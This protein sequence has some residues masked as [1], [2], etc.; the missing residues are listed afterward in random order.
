M[1]DPVTDYAL[2]VLDGKLPAGPYVIWACERHLRDLEREDIF[3]DLEEV[4]RRVGFFKLLKHYKDPF[5]GAPFELSPWQV[6]RVGS[7][8]GWKRRSDGLRRFRTA[9]TEIPRKNGKTTE[10]AGVGLSGMV[11]DGERGA[12]VY[13]VATK[14]DQAKIVWQDATKMAQAT[15]ELNKRLRFF[16]SAIVF[17]KMSARFMPLGRDSK[18]LDGLN[19]YLGLYDEF[20]AW[21]DRELRGK[22]RQGMGSRQQPLEWIVTT[23]GVD[24]ETLAFE[25]RGHAL[26]VLNP[27]LEDFDDDTLFAYIACP[28]PDDDP[29]DPATWWRANPNLEVSKSLKYLEGLW[30]TARMIPSEMAD[31]LTYQLNIW[32]QS[33]ERWLDLKRVKDAEV[34]MELSELAA[35]PC[36]AG[37]DLAE[38]GDLSAKCD[39]FIA[40]DGVWY[41]L[42]KFWCPEDDILKRSQLDKVPYSQWVRQGYLTSTPGN[43]TDFD[44][45]EAEVRASA[46]ALEVKELLYDRWKS[47]TIV[48]NLERDAVVTTVPYG[49]GYKDQSPALKEIERRFLNGTLKFIK[50]P[51]FSWCC[52]NAEVMRDPAGNIKLTKKD[53]RKRID[54]LA[55]LAN[56]VGGALLNKEEAGPSV[57]EDRGIIEL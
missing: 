6:F 10:M 14:R 23:A 54:G 39:L 49:Q 19:P 17:E 35:W 4:Q 27:E 16:V 8:Y 13:S 22:I 15:P 5:Y 9:Y 33:S 52:S 50:N 47:Q 51:V 43:A 46:E 29:G 3:L 20:H 34:E 41:A 12:E 25:L 31:F 18:S 53:P 7:V 56:A 42:F 28:F 26:N 21:R 24:T 45:I 36:Y 38:V 48:Q 40:P 44:F 55:A 1:N 37:L 32:G 30:S 2:R 57:Y 11:L